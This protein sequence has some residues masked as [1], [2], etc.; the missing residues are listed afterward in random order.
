MASDRMRRVNVALDNV[1]ND[2]RLVLSVYGK[3]AAAPQTDAERTRYCGYVRTIL[4]RYPRIHD[5][6]VWNE[7]NSAMFWQPQYDASKAS[8]APAQYERLLAACYGQLHAAR[9][10]LN[11]ISSLAPRG[12]DDP[13]TP[14]V[15]RH[16]QAR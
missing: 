10:G 13:R 5:V 9:P 3:P 4:A 15:A 16:A 1:P 11:V 7:V 14:N 8:V 2:V 6:V 12:N